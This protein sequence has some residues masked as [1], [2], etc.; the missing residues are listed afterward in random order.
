MKLS[1]YGKRN[2]LSDNV[3]VFQTGLIN[4]SNIN[5]HLAPLYLTTLTHFQAQRQRRHARSAGG[6]ID[7]MRAKPFSRLHK[8][9]STEVFKIFI[10]FLCFSEM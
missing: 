4:D 3:A 2:V 5:R 7:V 10:A 8:T 9:L 6:K 1:F